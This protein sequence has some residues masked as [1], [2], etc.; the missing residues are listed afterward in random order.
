M[1]VFLTNALANVKV[2][3]CWSQRFLGFH[4][5]P[6]LPRQYDCFQTNNRPKMKQVASN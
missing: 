4:K 5:L 1:E 3:P 2:I 6:T